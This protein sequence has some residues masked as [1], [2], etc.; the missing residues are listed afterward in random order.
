MR[1]YIVTLKCNEPKK[2]KPGLKG[3][4]VEMHAVNF[5]QALAKI[6]LRY[7][8]EEMRIVCIREKG[9]KL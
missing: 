3:V 9:A 8:L 6:E 2:S 4:A 1:T 7:N 5:D